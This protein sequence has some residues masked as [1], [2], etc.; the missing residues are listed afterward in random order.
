M[1]GLSTLIPTLARAAAKALFMFS[2]GC[3]T[4]AV[5]LRDF[6]AEITDVRL[7]AVLVHRKGKRRRIR[8]SY[9]TTGILRLTL[10]VLRWPSRA[11]SR[12]CVRLLT[13]SSP[14]LRR[15]TLPPVWRRMH[16]QP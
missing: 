15:K 6:D 1:L 8:W 13:R 4:S 9:F 14:W 11:G 2:S 3:R 7:T 16:W 12:V 10:Q 5:G